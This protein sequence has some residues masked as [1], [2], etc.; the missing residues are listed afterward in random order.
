[1]KKFLKGLLTIASVFIIAIA[2][3]G[4]GNE[5]E[6]PNNDNNGGNEQKPSG[7][8]EIKDIT[9]SNWEKVVEDNFGLKL[10]LPSGWSVTAASSPNKKTNVEIKFTKG[11]TETYESFGEKLFAELKAD[12]AG[13]ITKYGDASTIYNSF[14]D[15]NRSGIVSMKAIVDAAKNNSLIVQYY[16]GSTVQLSLL[17]N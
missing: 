1:M 9:T 8:T 15:A 6:K 13:D 17:R 7:G 14:A 2:L 5:E 10:S 16:D 4:C 12:A 11:G 3:T